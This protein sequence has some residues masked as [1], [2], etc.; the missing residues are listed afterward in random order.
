MLAFEPADEREPGMRPPARKNR[1]QNRDPENCCPGAQQQRHGSIRCLGCLGCL[2][3]LPLARQSDCSSRIE[4]FA[5]L[6]LLFWAS[7]QR[8]AAMQRNQSN[9][10]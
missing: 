5:M 10:D 3:D 4:I 2:A 9:V 1:S 8:N 7:E 6:H